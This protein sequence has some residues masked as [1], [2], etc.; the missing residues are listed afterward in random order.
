MSSGPGYDI[1]AI[2]TH[3][4]FFSSLDSSSYLPDNANKM[5]LAAFVVQLFV[6]LKGNKPSEIFASV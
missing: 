1:C 6:R 2:C 5:M 3:L 4:L